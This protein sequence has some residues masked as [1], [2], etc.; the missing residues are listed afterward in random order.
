MSSKEVCTSASAATTRA[1]ATQWQL[2]L[3]VQP[4]LEFVERQVFRR[5][6]ESGHWNAVSAPRSLLS[7]AN[8]V[9]VDF[10]HP[11]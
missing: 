5:L 10:Y 4:L 2:L 7:H 9:R 3:S 11:G 8:H 6:V 1:R